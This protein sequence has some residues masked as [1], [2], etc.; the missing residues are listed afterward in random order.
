MSNLGAGTVLKFEAFA[1]ISVGFC[2]LSVAQ[3][4]GGMQYSGCG[5]PETF[6]AI[7]HIVK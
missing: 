2:I 5:F 4:I 6:V 3:R 1:D 7:N